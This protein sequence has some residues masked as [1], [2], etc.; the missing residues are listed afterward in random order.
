[1]LKAMLNANGL[2]MIPADRALLSPG[3]LVD[4][5]ILSGELEMQ[6]S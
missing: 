3:D 1:M 2:A 4:V 5:H 6:E